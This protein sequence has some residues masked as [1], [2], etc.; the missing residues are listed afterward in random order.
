M[1]RCEVIV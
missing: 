1:S